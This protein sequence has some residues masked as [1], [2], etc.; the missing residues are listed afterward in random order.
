MIMKFVKFNKPHYNPSSISVTKYIRRGTPILRPEEILEQLCNAVHPAAATQYKAFFSSEL[1]GIITE[2]AFMMIHVDDHMVH[3]GHS[4]FDTCL[5]DKGAIYLFERHLDRFFNSAKTA[6]VRTLYSRDRIRKIIME[7]C[8]ASLI[9]EGEVRFWLSV[10]RGG[11]G[12]TTRECIM[13]SFYV[14]VIERKMDTPEFTELQRVISTT[15]PAKSGLFATIN[16]T[17]Y[18]PNAMS[19]KE[20][21]DNDAFQGIFLD[22]NGY[23]SESSN[24]NLLIY[25]GDKRLVVPSFDNCQAGCTAKRIIELVSL[26]LSNNTYKNRNDYAWLYENIKSAEFVPLLRPREVRDLSKELF[27][28]GTSGILTPVRQWDNEW[29]G[30]QFAFRNSKLFQ[31]LYTLLRQDMAYPGY[32]S[33]LLTPISYNDSD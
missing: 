1:G 10:G 11:F 27:L 30:D 13:P 6:S 5:I 24:R 2:P 4:V 16:S 32:D 31:V 14:Q 17:N 15:V 12:L 28:V 22:T 9:K 7:T 18:L 23:V 8:A 26:F 3:R 20:A 29:I 33:T 19:L 25:T 21:E